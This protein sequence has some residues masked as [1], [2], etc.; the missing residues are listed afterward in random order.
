[1]TMGMELRKKLVFPPVLI[2]RPLDTFQFILLSYRFK[3][4]GESFLLFQV[5]FHRLEFLWNECMFHLA[6]DRLL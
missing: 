2:H 3:K 4:M 6:M 1:M 5:V